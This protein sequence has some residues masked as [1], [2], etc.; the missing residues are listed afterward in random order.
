M[1]DISMI[2]KSLPSWLITSRPVL[3]RRF[4]RS[5]SDP[6]IDEEEL[7]ESNPN[8]AKIRYANGRESTVSISD[9]APC[10]PNVID[11]PD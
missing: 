6:L 1:N 11:I 2:G 8:F 5:K 7:L 3:L 9:L 4:V 10:P